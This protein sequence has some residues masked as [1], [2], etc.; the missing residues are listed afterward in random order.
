MIKPRYRLLSLA[1]LLSALFLWLMIGLSSAQ[2]ATPTV[3]ATAA[4][5]GVAQTGTNWIG[6]FYNTADLTGNVVATALFPL[7]LNKNWGT[8]APTDGNNAAIAGVNPENWSARFTTAVSITAGLYDFILSADDGARVYIDG[9]LILDNFSNTGLITQIATVSLA[10]G[11][12]TLIVDYNDK[13]GNALLQLSWVT[14]AGTPAPTGTTAPIAT[15]QVASVRGLALRTGPYKG[16]SLVN[17]LRPGK[18]YTLLARN[19]SEGLYTWYYVQVGDP[20]VG[21]LQFGWASGRYLTITGTPDVLPFAGSLFDQIDGAPDVGVTGVTRSVMN[22]R[23]RPSER[24]R[25]IGQIPW[26]DTVTIIGRTIQD[27]R[28]FWYQVRYNGQV[29]WILAAYVGTRGSMDL[30]PIR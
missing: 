8:G 25:R 10:G 1:A 12:Y 29:G 13:A 5:S 23:V 4:S 28:N 9:T 11:T 6:Q 16:A 15:G 19:T 17:V 18:D 30:V 22:F 24:T 26:G 2:T 27:G 3:V 14:S 20:T 21:N 7:G